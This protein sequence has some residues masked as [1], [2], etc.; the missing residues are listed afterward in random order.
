MIAATHPVSPEEVMALA[1]GELS[2]AEASSVAAYIAECA[3]CASLAAQ[4][5]ATS[6]TFAKW[7]VS[8]APARLEE[9]VRSA[10]D[11]NAHGRKPGR[12]AHNASLSIRNWK[13]WA[14]GGS[15][16][17][18]GVLILVAFEVS[19][20]YY[21]DHAVTHH[22]IAASVQQDSGAENSAL[23][24]PPPA[25]APA[26]E[27]FADVVGQSDK[28][29]APAQGLAMPDLAAP[30]SRAQKSEALE[31][32]STAPPPRI[33]EPIAPMIA[34]SVSLTVQVRDRTASRTTCVSPTLTLQLQ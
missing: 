22:Q 19:M 4:L 6:A 27:S 5:S 25:A 29:V 17:L 14:I 34:H 33:A 15:G 30:S 9:A 2:G 32:R 3:E 7:T 28:K 26:R 24:A 1:D 21:D 20:R 18:A 23:P 11:Q 10:A 31:A 8:E 16:A 12:P 13:L